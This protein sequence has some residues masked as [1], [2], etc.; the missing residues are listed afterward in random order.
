MANAAQAVHV[1][2]GKQL[3]GLHLI[4]LIR[5]VSLTWTMA[6]HTADIL[7]EMRAADKLLL[8]IGMAHRASSK[9]VSRGCLRLVSADVTGI[10]LCASDRQSI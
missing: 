5:H 9:R 8:D 1:F 4:V 7:V 2:S 10:C 3:V 6:L